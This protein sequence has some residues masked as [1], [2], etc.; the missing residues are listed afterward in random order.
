MLTRFLFFLLQLIFLA[1]LTAPPRSGHRDCCILPFYPAHCRKSRPCWNQIQQ[2]ST[3]QA[4]KSLKSQKFPVSA[5]LKIAMGNI[6][7][8]D[9]LKQKAH[10]SR[11]TSCLRS[12]KKVK[13]FRS[14]PPQVDLPR[15]P[16]PRRARR[17]IPHLMERARQRRCAHP[18]SKMDPRRAAK[19]LRSV[20]QSGNRF[21]RMQL[22]CN[23]QLF[24]GPLRWPRKSPKSPMLIHFENHSTTKLKSCN[25]GSTFCQSSCQ[26]WELWKKKKPFKKVVFGPMLPSFKNPSKSWWISLEWVDKWTRRTRRANATSSDIRVTSQPS[27]STSMRSQRFLAFLWGAF[28]YGNIWIEWTKSDKISVGWWKHCKFLS[29]VSILCIST[30]AGFSSSIIYL[31]VVVCLKTSWL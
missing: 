8:W 6:S 7:P 29:D 28:W 4:E 11:K 24:F 10:E 14:Q 2:V 3:C 17:R 18:S 19:S 30:G 20:E 25:L 1:D 21:A 16:T 5:G 9:V 15:N 13:S 22:S 26:N 31:C 27:Q 12:S 23:L